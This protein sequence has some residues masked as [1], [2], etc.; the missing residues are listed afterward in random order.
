LEGLAIEDVGLFYGYLVY[1]MVIWYVFP[2]FGV[3]C[4]EKSGNPAQD[5]CYIFAKKNSQK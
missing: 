1:F 3:L 5:Q 2:R 4:Q